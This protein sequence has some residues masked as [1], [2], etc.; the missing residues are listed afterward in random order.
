MKHHGSH[1]ILRPQASVHALRRAL[2]HCTTSLIFQLLSGWFWAIFLLPSV[3]HTLRFYMCFTVRHYPTSA[4]LY[5][6]SITLAATIRLHLY[7][8]QGLLQVILTGF[9]V[10]AHF[11][12]CSLLSHHRCPGEM[13]LWQFRTLQVGSS[14]ESRY[15]WFQRNS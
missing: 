11:V 3:L 2:Q 10:G 4:V 7:N 6:G 8:H 15:H 9:L 14:C 5:G 1:R 12:S 13:T